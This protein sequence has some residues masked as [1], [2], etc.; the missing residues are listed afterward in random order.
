MT[1]RPASG[2]VWLLG[3]P[4]IGKTALASQLAGVRHRAG[5][6]VLFGRCDESL[7][8]PYQPLAQ[9]LRE[10]VQR[11]DPVIA[12]LDLP[13]RTELTL[14]CPEVAGTIPSGLDLDPDR[15]RASGVPD[16]FA[17]ETGLTGPTIGGGQDRLFLAVCN[18]LRSA[19][20][21]APTLLV[22]D[23]L[24]WAT[25]TTVL[26]VNFALR[27]VGSGRLC[28][29]ATA[30][31][32]ECPDLLRSI[33]DETTARGG[34]MALHLGG[35]S[36]Q[37][38]ATLVGPDVQAEDATQIH[39]QTA[40]NPFFVRA[41]L[42]GGASRSDDVDSA[43][44]R[45]VARLDQSTRDLL[46]LAALD[47]LEFDLALVAHAMGAATSDALIWVDAAVTAA[48]VE[49]LGPNRFRFSH[50]LVRENLAAQ[51]R[52]TRR[53]MLHGM[54]ARAY[55]AIAPDSLARLAWHWAEA[56][57]DVAGRH[58]AVAHLLAAGRVATAAHDHD[59]AARAYRRAGEL[60]GD[61]PV[62][63]R[64][65]VALA[66]GSELLAAGS[67][68]E[69]TATALRQAIRLG[70]DTDLSVRAMIYLYLLHV[71]G[72]PNPPAENLA[73]IEAVRSEDP[74]RKIQ[75]SMLATGYR[76][77]I[78]GR[79]AVDLEVFERDFAEAKLL[80]DP[81]AIGLATS[82]RSTLLPYELAEERVQDSL[83]A[84][85]H[86]VR[87]GDPL[88]VTTVIGRTVAN[89]MIAGW[90]D[91]AT[92]EAARI[93]TEGTR[94]RSHFLL[95]HSQS[96]TATLAVLRGE[97]S[98]AE[99]LAGEAMAAAE[100]MEGLD[101][102]GMYGLQMFSIRREQGR[103]AEVAPL[104]RVMQRLNPDRAGM[105][106]PGLAA[107]YAEL[108]MEAEAR[109]ELQRHVVDGVVLLADDDLLPITASY[110]ADAA[111]AVRDQDR[112]SAIYRLM[113]PW[114]DV[115]VALLHFACY[116]PASRYL[117]ML[118]F[119]MGQTD[120]AEAHLQQALTSCRASGMVT[121]EV[122]ARYW[123][124]RVALLQRRQPDAVAQFERATTLA[125]QLRMA[126][127]EDR[128]RAALS[129]APG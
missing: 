56:A 30:R 25:D 72:G 43:V 14:L 94:R 90:L 27:E 67:H 19:A 2:V 85:T 10:R 129:G 16:R 33:I 48:L 104:L 60:A 36:S 28:V 81:M 77:Y 21:A 89:L 119:T 66:L 47:G 44:R 76:Y 101:A 32:T 54:L 73:D 69:E 17:N 13:T 45:R 124:G 53:T 106:R 52:P 63:V 110:L 40:G 97:L 79:T 42:A 80:D 57:L 58:L 70:G 55:E 41:L 38:V 105:W 6:N 65:E 64:A 121:Y 11:S 78:G 4:G 107:T 112:A 128:C 51:V 35:L 50:A 18:W 31:D 49:E 98:G 114:Q 100:G 108:G 75:L 61:E 96:A 117:G 39:A 127:W 5:W 118:A 84:M 37:D 26:L 125:D 99:S 83:A 120:L 102:N 91:Q 82:I 74:V 122:H 34:A 109:S 12:A 123:L 87:T 59:E 88:L 95:H 115:N 68:S 92:A 46:Q 62:G 111:V 1:P 15:G 8:T 116:G 113:A 71:S 9:A 93:L 24:H 23:D 103:L 3:E 7:Q 20:T 22:L 29:L 86:M 126:G